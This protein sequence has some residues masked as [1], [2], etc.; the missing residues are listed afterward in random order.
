ML[1][2]VTSF[3]GPVIRY[4]RR[5]QLLHTRGKYSCIP[6]AQQETRPAPTNKVTST[7]TSTSTSTLKV[8]THLRVARKGARHPPHLQPSTLNPQPSPSPTAIGLWSLFRG[9]WTVALAA[10]QGPRHCCDSAFAHEPDHLV[11]TTAQAQAYTGL[12]RLHLF[13]YPSPTMADLIDPTAK[14]NYPIILGDGLLGKTSNEIFTGIR[15]NH[16][17]SFP[18]SDARL[19][20]S[21]PGKTSSYDLNFSNSDGTVGFAGT[22]STDDD[23]YVLWFDPERKAFILDKVD[24]TF[25]MNLTRIPGNSNPEELRRRYPHLENGQKVGDKKSAAGK[26]RLKSTPKA[27]E[28]SITVQTKEMQKKFDK[29]HLDKKSSDK[30]FL[31]KKPLVEKKPIDKKPLLDKKAAV[32][33]KPAV[34][35]KSA[36]DKKLTD[37]KPTDRKPTD[38]DK[39]TPEKNQTEKKSSVD[40][41]PTEKKSSLE[42]KMFE[43]KQLGKPLPKKIDLKLPVPEPPKPSEPKPR[44][45]KDEDEDEE[46]EDDDGDLLIEYPGAEAPARQT[47]FSPAF[48][49]PRRFDDFM[50][51][52]ESEV[53]EEEEEEEEAAAEEE[54]DGT[55]DDVDFK[56]PSPVKHASQSHSEPME[57]DEEEEEGEEDGDAEAGGANDAADLEYDLE[58]ELENAFEKLDNN[59]QD[60]GYYY[61]NNNANDDDESEISE[62]D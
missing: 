33:K 47:H 30:V 2:A 57:I 20:P 12:T 38:T 9:R 17:P 61:S 51:Q 44:K 40:K 41:R 58:Q 37:R 39:R 14:G 1:S 31:E 24:S 49:A 8:R 29:K 56:L 3:D 5:Q 59:D 62:E 27:D 35:K 6:R 42:K 21:L 36:V 15:Y 48:P 4:W 53:E 11:A 50:D 19:K 18:A 23:D 46:D 28:K 45:K 13:T 32:D 7:S 55:M 60:N 34:D 26:D 10:E 54:E 25:N 52:R 22:R 43:K 16:K